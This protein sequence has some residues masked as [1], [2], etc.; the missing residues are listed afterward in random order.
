LEPKKTGDGSASSSGASET[1]SK[2]SGHGADETIDNEIPEVPGAPSVPKLVHDFLIPD[3]QTYRSGRPTKNPVDPPIL[4]DS[5]QPAALAKSLQYLPT[6]Y[7]VNILNRRTGQV[8]SG[9]KAV[10]LNELAALIQE[11]SSLEPIIP[12]PGAN[13]E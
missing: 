3:K 2:G 1:A 6:D 7:K 12:P 4:I 5:Q 13:P 8:L 11:D 10:P 9:A